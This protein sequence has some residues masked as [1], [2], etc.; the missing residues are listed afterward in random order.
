MDSIIAKNPRARH[1]VAKRFG[2]RQ[3]DFQSHD[4]TDDSVPA[5]VPPCSNCEHS[6]CAC[7]S[8]ASPPSDIPNDSP[9]DIPNNPP[10]L[11]DTSKDFPIAG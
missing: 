3:I 5:S 10:D 7:Q 1:T 2:V 9:A 4:P 6:P 11:L 8:S